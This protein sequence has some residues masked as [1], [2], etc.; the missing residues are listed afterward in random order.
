MLLS[1]TS[2]ASIP[3]VRQKGCPTSPRSR[4]LATSNAVSAVRGSEAVS[5]G[6]RSVAQTLDRRSERSCYL[7]RRQ[8]EEDFPVGMV[9][10]RYSQGRFAAIGK[11]ITVY[12]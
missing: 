7:P 5:V 12:I 3:L 6:D 8:R 1:D 2:K 11:K 4:H 10:R 9:Q